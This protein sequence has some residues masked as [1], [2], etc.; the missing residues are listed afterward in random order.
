M[1]RRKENFKIRKKILRS[2]I[3][4]DLYNEI[5]E[6]YRENIKLGY[7]TFT[8]LLLSLYW[9]FIAVINEMKFYV[10]NWVC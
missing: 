7:I 2:K 6:K 3:T 4:Q 5:R 10:W 9:F 1:I 8:L